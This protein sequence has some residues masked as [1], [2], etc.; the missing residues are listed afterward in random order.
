MSPEEIF[1]QQKNWSERAL[2]LLR[3]LLPLMAPVGRYK[4]WAALEH[5]T[6]AELLSACARSSESVLLLCA[7]GQLWDADVVG[8][9]V[10]EG[11]LKFVYL[12]QSRDLFQ[13]RHQEYAVDLFD[14]ALL[15]DHKK[16]LELLEVVK[17]SASREWLPIREILLSDKEVAGIKS[18]LPQAQ[19]RALETKWGFAGLVGQLSQS[20]D[21]DFAHSAALL[22]GY[23]MSSHT[24]HA[25][26]IGVSVVMERERRSQERKELVH[27]SH[28]RRLINDQLLFFWFR[29]VVGYRFV[30]ESTGALVEA[31]KQID[32][33]DSSFDSVVAQWMD[34][35]YPGSSGKQTV[36]KNSAVE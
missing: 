4:Q 28:L 32:M 11:T 15:K 36:T 31:K 5:R 26:V 33:L 30:G 1:D 18:R 24:L 20:S 14:I 29:L 21:P 7:Y 12:L 16:A 3:G 22:H 17:N 10:V 13:Q 35:E 6:V 23:A 27:L 2:F 25:D 19:R 8:R 34:V 9:S